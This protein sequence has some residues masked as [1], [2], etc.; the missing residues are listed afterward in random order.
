MNDDERMSNY[1]YGKAEG[2]ER[3][4]EWS[5]EVAAEMDDRVKR[6]IK[7]IREAA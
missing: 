7:A 4:A 1:Y 5:R 3:L 2:A 6:D